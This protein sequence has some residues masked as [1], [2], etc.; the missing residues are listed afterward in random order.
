MSDEEVESPR[1][2]AA[3]TEPEDNSGEE[4]EGATKIRFR[5]KST[6]KPINHFTVDG[7]S[8]T[9]I[10]NLIFESAKEHLQPW[11]PP[12]M[13]EYKK[14]DSDLYLWKR[15]ESYQKAKVVSVNSYRCPL[16]YS[17]GCNSMLRVLRNEVSVTIEIKNEHNAQSHK[18][19]HLKKLKVQEKSAIK[20]LVRGDPSL[21]AT[22]ARRMC[23]A[24]AVAEIPVAQ[25]RSVQ[26]LVRKT[27]QV[28]LHREFAGVH[29]DG[30]IQSFVSFKEA[31]WMTTILQ[32]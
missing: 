23:A 27:K 24:S 25:H 17:C 29:L 8:E 30:T 6:W 28:T 15:K 16:S 11:L 2:A 13:D 14:L 4:L 22:A 10:S 7:K 19:N 21:S 31:L 26:Y 18:I 5:T 20:A 12:L 1:G 9:D 32:Q 3:D